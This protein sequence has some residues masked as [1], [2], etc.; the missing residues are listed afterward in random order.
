MLVRWWRVTITQRRRGREDAEGQEKNVGG[1]GEHIAGCDV[2]PKDAGEVVWGRTFTQ[3]HRGREDAEGSEEN[4]G[5][6][7]RAH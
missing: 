4:V 3:R 2:K 6:G 5:W 1:V 7:W